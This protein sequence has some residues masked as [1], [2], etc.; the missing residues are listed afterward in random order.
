MDLIFTKEGSKWVVEFQ[1]TSDFNLHIERESNGDIFFYQRTTSAGDYDSI[2]I[3]PAIYDKVFDSDFTA[4]VFPKW[5]KII[6][7]SPVTNAVLTLRE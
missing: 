2:H 5:I 4:S 1:V 6:S 3:V 7:K